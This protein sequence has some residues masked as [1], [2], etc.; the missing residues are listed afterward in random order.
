MRL[1]RRGCGMATPT[2]LAMP[3]RARAWASPVKSETCTCSSPSPSSPSSRVRVRVGGHR[4]EVRASSTPRSRSSTRLAIR[5]RP[6]EGSSSSEASTTGLHA[7]IS[8][9]LARGFGVEDEDEAALRSAA[10]LVVRVAE[11]LGDA[12]LSGDTGGEYGRFAGDPVELARRVRALRCVLGCDTAKA[13]NLVRQ[14]PW[15]LLLSP[16]A[17]Q[18]ALLRMRIR[19]GPGCDV[20]RAFIVC[21][22]L[23]RDLV[24]DLD[25]ALGKGPVGEHTPGL[26]WDQV[27]EALNALREKPGI[28]SD[29]LLGFLVAEEPE[30][31][32]D[33]TVLDA[34]LPQLRELD[35]R[36]V[37]TAPIH[38]D[39][40]RWL[41]NFV[42][43][44]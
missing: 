32:Y 13:A 36:H 39:A 26:T 14:E 43:N 10:S 22:S 6:D 35:P 29:A 31:L 24:D 16:D 19:L 44:Y 2:A 38:R 7:L 37:A 23:F 34:R 5:D 20:S 12:R 27:D 25:E 4:C 11:R 28:I 15:L 30:L 17:V 9:A 40:Q 21:P 33:H 1:A 18:A 42:V 41:S 8:G 3:P